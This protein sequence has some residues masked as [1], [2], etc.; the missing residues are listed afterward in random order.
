MQPG[1]ELLEGQGQVSGSLRNQS[2]AVELIDSIPGKGADP[3]CGHHFHAVFRPEA[4]FSGSALE[5][6][7]LQRAPGIFEGKEMISR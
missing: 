2:V 7:A 3:A 1:L 6:H 4:D 5:H